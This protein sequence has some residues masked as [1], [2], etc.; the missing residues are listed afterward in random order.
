MLR[1]KPQEHAPR[2]H[3]PALQLFLWSHFMTTLYSVVTTSKFL[4]TKI[5]QV[6]VHSHKLL[7]IRSLDTLGW[8][9]KHLYLIHFIMTVSFST[10]LFPLSEGGE[11][12]YRLLFL[13]SQKGKCKAFP[14]SCV[15]GQ[16]KEVGAGK[17]TNAI[18][19]QRKKHLPFI[20][21]VL[22]RQDS[23]PQ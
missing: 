4:H 22:F 21:A 2:S 9:R 6:E 15:S 17:D 20:L 19:F 10:C 23:G 11:K 7:K 5:H 3:A 14:N 16:E 12:Y 8:F 1:S 13:F 18:S